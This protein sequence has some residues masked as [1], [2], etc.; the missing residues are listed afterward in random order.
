M[1]PLPFS[2]SPYSSSQMCNL[3]PQQ[4]Q[5]VV[6]ELRLLTQ[7]SDDIIINSMLNAMAVTVQASA[8]VFNPL[9][10]TPIPL[11]LYC[12][13]IA[14]SGA[15]KS[16]VDNI[17]SAPFRDFEQRQS[18][19]EK[20]HKNDYEHDMDVYNIRLKLLKAKLKKAIVSQHREDEVNVGA[21]LK[22]HK[23]TKPI[24]MAAP[25][26]LVSDITQPAL[27]RALSAPWRSLCLNTDEAGKILNG[28]DFSMPSFYN[29]LWDA[30]PFSIERI[31][32][33]HS[34][35]NNYRLSMNLMLQPSIFAKYIRIHGE[36]AKES[37]F[38]A[39]CLFSISQPPS[40]LF[41]QPRTETI[42]TPHLDF[43]IKRIRTL[44]D[45][46][47]QDFLLKGTHERRLL[48]AEED[49]HILNINENIIN[50][51]NGVV[52]DNNNQPL[53]FTLRAAEHILRLAGIMHFFLE[54]D[55]GNTIKKDMINHANSM[56]QLYSIQYQQAVDFHEITESLIQALFTFIRTNAQYH[57]ALRDTAINK[58]VLL[59]KG[60]SKLRKKENLDMALAILESRRKI[61]LRRIANA[62]YINLCIDQITLPS[63]QP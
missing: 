41:Q 50:Y 32:T 44:L 58:T 18:D 1:Q 35:V 24:L 37:G 10:N 8:D 30:K 55:N 59:Q 15:R 48:K 49:M 46:A 12:I 34:H 61:Q 27:Q 17:L 5:H 33:G 14:E 45:S 29:F 19:D 51:C 3:L 9:T 39:R 53:Q 47:Y 43:F 28:K 54:G 26:I 4:L 38:F 25:K 22:S 11:S 62:T 23:E 42:S 7:A 6:T 16:T 57:H 2:L 63:Y 56:T 21:E 31:S 52:F 60:P 13:T 36:L 40:M 20:T